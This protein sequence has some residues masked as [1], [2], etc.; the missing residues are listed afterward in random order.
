LVRAVLRRLKTSIHKI[1]GTVDILRF[2]AAPE[3]GE[4]GDFLGLDEI[5][6]R[7]L[8]EEHVAQHLFAGSAAAAMHPRWKAP[9]QS[10]KRRTS[11]YNRLK[12]EK[13]A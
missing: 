8:A 5:L 10:G 9:C 3:H 6:R 2:E 1:L 7:L 4:R 13:K 12:D 11:G